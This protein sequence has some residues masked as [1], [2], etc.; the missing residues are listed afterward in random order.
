MERSAIRERRSGWPRISQEIHPGYGPPTVISVRLS[1][2]LQA[3]PLACDLAEG[4]AELVPV[5]ADI[6]QL[7][8]VVLAQRG[9]CRFALTTGDD[10]R[11]PAVDEALQKD[12]QSS[13]R[14]L[15]ARR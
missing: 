3:H 14:D 4:I 15:C 1:A 5:D 13:R 12:S 11:D 2:L 10:A 8:V 6:L 7:P 9:A